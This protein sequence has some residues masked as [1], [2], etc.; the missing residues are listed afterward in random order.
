MTTCATE[1]QNKF[2]LKQTLLVCVV[3][4]YGL[5]AEAKVSREEAQQLG[6]ALTPI[7]AERAGNAAGTIPEWKAFRPYGSP[8]GKYALDPAMAA[9][10]PLLTI[11]KANMARYGEQL[12]AGHKKLLLSYDSYK[13]TVF[14]T[15]REVSWPDEIADATQRNATSCER[16]SSDVLDGCRLGFPF[17]IPRDG[18]E[19]IWNHKLKWRGEALTRY[20]N[21]LIVQTDGQYQLTKLVEDVS[22]P[23]A[24]IRHPVPITRTSG[25]FTK[26][27]SQTLAPPRL[28]GTYILLIDRVGAGGKGR[29]AW[30][31]APGMRRARRATHI[32]FDNPYEGT[33]GHQFY[34]QI[35]MFNGSLSR[36]DWK[37]AGK[38]EMYVSYHA[39]RIAGSK[40][41][42]GDMATPRHLNQDLA[43]YELHRIWVVEATVKPGMTHTLKRRV[44][45]LDEDGW[46]ILAV[47]GYD[48]RDQLYQFQ[49]G[50]YLISARALAGFTSPE[51]IY[52]FDSGRYFV[53]GMA[54]EDQPP[55]TAVHFEDDHFTPEAL[56]RRSATAP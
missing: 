26:Y 3:C 56:Q 23:Y 9:E 41:K 6:Q 49:E 34:D 17:P 19:P 47:D 8:P 30:Q 13:M 4:S 5:S 21:Q 28:A 16:V 45:Y 27:L 42:Y 7:G 46:N 12:T 2:T 14:P 32:S 24:S 50:H 25:E 10:K 22:Y 20:N 33:D 39:N 31:F 38:R 37:L 54:N 44:F 35:D 52:H 18:A 55:N 15:H 53:T 48:N 29:L 43:R 40:T 11:T 1:P 36:Y 51:V